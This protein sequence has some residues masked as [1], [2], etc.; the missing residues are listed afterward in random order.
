[1]VPASYHSFFTDTAQVAGTLIGLLFVAVSLAPEKLSGNDADFQVKA[2]I[3]FAALINGLVIGLTALL[4]GDHLA[5]TATILACGGISSAIGLGA[6]SF[7][8]AHLHQRFR[9]LYRVTGLLALF[10]I[11]L[12][13]SLQL[14]SHPHHTGPIGVQAILIIAGFVFAV[15]RAWELV[16]AG[17]SGI[18]TM[19]AR[20]LIDHRASTS[21]STPHHPATHPDTPESRLKATATDR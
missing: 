13:N 7:R 2:G 3:A 9:A 19:F 18:L 12:V 5:I 15:E 8:H 17:G 10:T 11:Q 21:E 6:I 4:P 20:L 14:A 16:G 1:M